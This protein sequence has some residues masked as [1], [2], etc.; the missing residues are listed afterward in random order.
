MSVTSAVSVL[1]LTFKIWVWIPLQSLDKYSAN[2][3]LTHK[4]V[5]ISI[6]GTTKSWIFNVELY[7]Y[8][9]RLNVSCSHFWRTTLNDVVLSVPS[10]EMSKSD[11]LPCYV[12]L[13]WRAYKSIRSMQ[14]IW[15]FISAL[16]KHWSQT[17]CLPLMLKGEFC[18][19]A[20]VNLIKGNI[21]C[22]FQ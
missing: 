7:W 4:R 11:N 10:H 21:L 9:S 17:C 5:N 2:T 19:P 12:N 1:S 13:K 15:M 20:A 14:W 16:A 22:H 3:K 8:P 6:F 18:I